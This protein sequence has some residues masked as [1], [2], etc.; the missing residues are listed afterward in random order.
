MSQLVGKGSSSG[1]RSFWLKREQRCFEWRQDDQDPG[2][3]MLFELPRNMLLAR[4]ECGPF[5]QAYATPEIH[6]CMQYWFKN[7]DELLLTSL[8]SLTVTRWLLKYGP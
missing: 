4:F 1:A 8:L 6:G 7:H 2:V 5:N 3:F